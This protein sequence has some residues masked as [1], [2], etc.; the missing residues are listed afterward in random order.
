MGPGRGI[1]RASG[2]GNRSRRLYP[3]FEFI[4]DRFE[5]VGKARDVKMQRIVMAVADAGIDGRME[6]RNEPMLGPHTGDEVKERQ[7]VVLRGGKGGIGRLRVIVP[8][9]PGGAAARLYQFDMEEKPLQGT[10]EIRRLLE[11]RLTPGNCEIVIEQHLSGAIDDNVGLPPSIRTL[12]MTEIVD[13]GADVDVIGKGPASV[14]RPA[15]IV[16]HEIAR[17]GRVRIV[18]FRARQRLPEMRCEIP[19]QILF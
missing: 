10:G 15:G 7:P 2:S 14:I 1:G 3:P 5:A 11:P 8:T 19:F 18:V 4:D 9:A 6:S 13:L 17:H 12:E 16:D